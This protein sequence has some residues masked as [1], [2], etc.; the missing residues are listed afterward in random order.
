[1]PLPLPPIYPYGTYFQ[2]NYSQGERIEFRGLPDWGWEHPDWGDAKKRKKLIAN[3]PKDLQVPGDWITWKNHRL[4]K[5]GFYDSKNNRTYDVDKAP[6]R[7]VLRE[8][9]YAANL[10]IPLPAPGPDFPSPDHLEFKIWLQHKVEQISQ[11]RSSSN[12]LHQQGRTDDVLEA[13]EAEDDLTKMIRKILD[14]DLLKPKQSGKKLSD[15]QKHTNLMLKII[16]RKTVA[17]TPKDPYFEHLSTE[18]FLLASHR[19]PDFLDNI[20]RQIVKVLI[21]KSKTISPS[22][23]KSSIISKN[24]K[25]YKFQEPPKFLRYAKNNGAIVTDDEVKADIQNNPEFN[26]KKG[27]SHKK[28]SAWLERKNKNNDL[29]S[30]KSD[31]LKKL[32]KDRGLVTSGNKAALRSRLFI[33]EYEYDRKIELTIRLL[34]ELNEKLPDSSQIAPPDD[35][36]YAEVETAAVI[37]VEILSKEVERVILE[38]IEEVEKIVMNPKDPCK[39]RDKKVG[40]TDSEK[41]ELE[42]LLGLKWDANKNQYG[43][44]KGEGGCFGNWNF[45]K[46]KRWS[47]E[48]AS[49]QNIKKTIN[50]IIVNLQERELIKFEGMNKEEYQQ[51]FTS[52]NKKRNWKYG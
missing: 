23:R 2:R 21:G 11:G 49:R 48:D 33:A 10:N 25:I 13:K 29:H 45:N 18:Q 38:S 20:C 39:I 24:R 51:H 40:L 6:P 17:F 46:G 12:V 47:S 37:F 35:W 22:I 8:E 4:K 7:V 44:V 1:M 50:S 52:S 3:T 15:E 41:K 42:S 14:E 32:L 27:Y 5:R 16:G 19:K 9:W 28:F 30:K 34:E 43:P 36:Q 31:Q 26:N